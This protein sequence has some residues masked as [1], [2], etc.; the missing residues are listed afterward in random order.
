MCT[1]LSSSWSFNFSA[2]QTQSGRLRFCVSSFH[3]QYI[4]KWTETHHIIVVTMFLMRS[5]RKKTNPDHSLTNEFPSLS[6][7]DALVRSPVWN[8]TGASLMFSI[9]SADNKGVVKVCVL[10]PDGSC[11][12][13]AEI[14]YRS[15]PSCISI[16][17]NRTWIRYDWICWHI[18]FP[19]TNN[20]TNFDRY[21]RTGSTSLQE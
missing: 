20:T 6:L 4:K 3:R 14:T 10:L 11:H 21:D 2:L 7:C 16:T 12:G 13:N 5:L 19:I 9:P 8:N 15:S 17:P 1:A 18:V